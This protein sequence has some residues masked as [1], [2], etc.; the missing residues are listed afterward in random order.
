M[1]NLDTDSVMW[2]DASIDI[3]T[4][5]VKQLAIAEPPRK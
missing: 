3:T 1:V 4:D 2:P 5:V